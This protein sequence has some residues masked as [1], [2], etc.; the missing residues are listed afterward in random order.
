M[1]KKGKPRSSFNPGTISRTFGRFMESLGRR[2]RRHHPVSGEHTGETRP[3]SS[4]VR[5]V[6]LLVALPVLVLF[7]LL[8]VYALVAEGDPERL[9]YAP[10]V[11]SR[12]KYL[13]L[14]Y[15]TGVIFISS[16]V[17]A[18]QCMAVFGALCNWTTMLFAYV[19]ITGLLG[20]AVG[21][22]GIFGI[23]L[24]CI[25]M[26]HTSAS[27]H[28]ILITALMVIVFILTF[29]LLTILGLKLMAYIRRHA[30]TTGRYDAEAGGPRRSKRPYRSSPA[31]VRRGQK[32]MSYKSID[33]ITSPFNGGVGLDDDEEDEDEAYGEELGSV[34]VAGES[35]GGRPSLKSLL[36]QSP[37]T[38]SGNAGGNSSSRSAFTFQ[39]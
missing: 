19:V 34:Y 4:P 1:A 18:I 15:Q 30:A 13:L 36:P 27:D 21:V 24:S 28:S 39:V 3:L 8:L 35:M 10:D 2:F 32:R 22:I 16:C 26:S 23:V 6:F 7:F 17:V 9:K 5:F 31:A 37:S 29:Y 14:Q 11:T 20:T 25:L 33:A 12:L 38:I